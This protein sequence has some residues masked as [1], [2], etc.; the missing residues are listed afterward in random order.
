MDQLSNANDAWVGV[1]L[2]KSYKKIDVFALD[3]FED[4]VGSPKQK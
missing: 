3:F 1:V 4:S 2:V